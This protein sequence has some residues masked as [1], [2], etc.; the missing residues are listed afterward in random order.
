MHLGGLT[1]GHYPVLRLQTQES[2][3]FYHSLA[4]LT[5]VG[6]LKCYLKKNKRLELPMARDLGLDLP[7]LFMEDLIRIREETFGVFLGS[8]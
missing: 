1:R 6:K 2:M 7:S 8:C 4:N 3:W 5:K